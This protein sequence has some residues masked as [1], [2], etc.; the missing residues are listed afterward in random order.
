MSD[1][2][3]DSEKYSDALSALRAE[4]DRNL[5]VLRRPDASQKLQEAFDS[6]PAEIAAAANKARKR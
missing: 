6:T 5:A 3:K 2:S 4:W 1:I